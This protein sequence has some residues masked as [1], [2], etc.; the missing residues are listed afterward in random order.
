ML[1]C[2]GRRWCCVEKR[3]DKGLAQV[4]LPLHCHRPRLGCL[5]L[6]HLRLGD[7]R[8]SAGFSFLVFCEA[9]CVSSVLSVM[10]ICWFGV[11]NVREEGK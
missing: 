7:H 4:V 3:K 2:W 8:T 1:R 10:L 6:R 9:C 5:S 11:R